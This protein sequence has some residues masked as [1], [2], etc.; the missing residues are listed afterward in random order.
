MA[1]V[2]LAGAA[3]CS[4]HGSSSSSPAAPAGSGYA[5]AN[6]TDSYTSTS[7]S[8]ASTPTI[9]LSSLKPIG[10]TQPPE[11]G[12][13]Q[14][15]GTSEPDA[16]YLG[17]VE[18]SDSEKIYTYNVP[19]SAGSFTADVAVGDRSSAKQKSHVEF[20]VDSARVVVA[21]PE[22]GKPVSVKVDATGVKQITI[23]ELGTDV[24]GCSDSN[25]IVLRDAEF[26]GSNAQA[27]RPTDGRSKYLTDL[28]PVSEK[29]D[30][31]YNHDGAGVAALDGT[32][33]FHSVYAG[34]DD[35]IKDHQD[36][37]T[38]EYDLGRSAV[39]LKAIGGVA[40]NS[41]SSFTCTAQI[42][43][44]GKRVYNGPFAFGRTNP[45]DVPLT[46][47]LRLKII[48][49]WGGPGEGDCVIGDAR[50]IQKS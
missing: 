16:I 12:T 18:G 20:E 14:I 24:T 38:F 41:A 10:T 30:T 11:V 43:A 23:R 13:A 46:N 39:A 1:I 6:G 40:D 34:R 37:C 50:L 9:P 15:D 8:A 49:S 48:L 36:T 19:T 44:D 7:S 21:N 28:D 27:S 31:F 32:N 22:L 35:F 5:A 29:C 26:T 25:G 45:L 17:C 3:A 4:T 42:E 33:V 2:A 47:A